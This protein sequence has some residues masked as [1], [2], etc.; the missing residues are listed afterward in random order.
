MKRVMA[1]TVTR[2]CAA[3]LAAS[4]I[5]NSTVTAQVANPVSNPIFDDLNVWIA[6]ADRFKPGMMQR[7]DAITSGDEDVNVFIASFGFVSLIIEVALVQAENR[8]FLDTAPLSALDT[9]IAEQIRFL[10]AFEEA[11]PSRCRAHA[12]G[13][14]RALRNAIKKGTL[15]V[16][17]F[18]AMAALIDAMHAGKTSPVPLPTVSEGRENQ[19][20]RL[21][22]VRVSED[23]MDAIDR[24]AESE[25]KTPYV[26]IC[27]DIVAYLRFMQAI[28]DE[29]VRRVFAH[30]F[31]VELASG[32]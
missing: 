31:A 25:G 4:L 21:A 19:A 6:A 14:R 8:A 11:D 20:L 26:G 3:L 24:L 23:D 29:A 27:G 10:A 16:M 15:V 2:L 30:E 18:R 1:L 12:D 28:D 13:S 32:R 22:A 9:F 7:L 5:L 17:P